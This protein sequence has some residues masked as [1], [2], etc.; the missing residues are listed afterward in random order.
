MAVGG[1]PGDVG[2]GGLDGG[3]FLSDLVRVPFADAMLEAVPPAVDVAALASASD[4]LADGWRSVGPYAR[5]LAELD[6]CLPARR[7]ARRPGRPARSHRGLAGLV[8][9]CGLAHGGGHL[10]GDGPGRA[11]AHRFG[12]GAVRAE[13]GLPMIAIDEL[14]A[15]A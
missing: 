12:G 15:C 13:L 4:N 6:P 9:G 3:G 11:H 1:T 8:P 5:E 2:G 14:A 10:R 7:P